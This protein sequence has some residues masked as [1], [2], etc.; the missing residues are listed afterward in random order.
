PLLRKD[1]IIHP[2]Q[3]WQSRLAGADAALLIAAA[4]SQEQ[5]SALLAAFNE[6]RLDV[7]LE[8]HNE[9][10]LHKAA[11]ALTSFYSAAEIKINTMLGINN[12]NLS[13]FAVDLQTTQRLAAAIRQR[14]ADNPLL[15]STV[16]VSESGIA[17]SADMRQLAEFGASAFLIGESLTA[18]GEPGVNLARLIADFR[19]P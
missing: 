14:F 13:T 3:V 9:E 15:S 12:R 4:L 19:G 1:F 10:E 7:L 2:A 8:V 17:A 18:A 6:A 11:A 16:I 5:L